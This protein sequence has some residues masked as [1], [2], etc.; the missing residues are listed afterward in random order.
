MNL[1]VYLTYYYLHDQLLSKQDTNHLLQLNI[2]DHQAF[3]AGLRLNIIKYFL[4]LA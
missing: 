1:F 2:Y 4:F 3:S